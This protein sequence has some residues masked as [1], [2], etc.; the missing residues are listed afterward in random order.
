MS[1]GL[2]WRDDFIHRL[3]TDKIALSKNEFD[4]NGLLT[5]PEELKQVL[6]VPILSFSNLIEY[7]KQSFSNVF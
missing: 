5:M 3:D 4:G 7:R 1:L 2:F 6:F